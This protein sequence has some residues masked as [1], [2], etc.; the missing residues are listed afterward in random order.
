MPISNGILGMP[1]IAS[2]GIQVM[3][4]TDDS[5]MGTSRSTDSGNAKPR[6]RRGLAPTIERFRG[7]PP[8][9]RLSTTREPYGL[10]LRITAAPAGDRPCWPKQPVA[11]SCTNRIGPRSGPANWRPVW[12]SPGHQCGVPVASAWRAL[13]PAPE[14]QRAD[15]A[16][17]PDCEE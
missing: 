16:G 3:D 11:L 6:C 1:E 7:R 10:R 12:P 9:V 15:D 4:V 13:P 8:E 2:D 17:N 5:R 14:G